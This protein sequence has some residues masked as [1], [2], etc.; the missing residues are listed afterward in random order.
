MNSDSKIKSIVVFASGSG[1]NAVKLCQ[2]V[3]QRSDIKVNAIFCNNPQ[4]GVIQKMNDFNIPVIIFNREEFKNQEEFLSKINSYKPD[5]IALLGF[6]WKVPAYLVNAFPKKIVNLHPALLPKFGGKGMYGHF[7]HE[8]VKAANEK[9]TGISIHY[10]NE[11]FDE[12]EIIAQFKVDLSEHDN[13]ETI[14]EKIHV[15][16]QKHVSDTIIKLL[17]D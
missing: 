4:A 14:A 16:E 10:V 13:S 12:G 6:L 7:V 9:E 17:I 2:S 15:L 1:S 11:H 8:A 5:L 3:Q